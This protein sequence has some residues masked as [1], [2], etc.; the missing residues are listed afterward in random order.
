MVVV[1]SS[2][3][4]FIQVVFAPP[5]TKSFIPE[6]KT[7]WQQVNIFNSSALKTITVW[8]EWKCF[9]VAFEFLWQTFTRE[10]KSLFIFQIDDI[11]V[12]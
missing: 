6:S 9:P 10:D 5:T 2:W 3:F 8:Q 12:D 4:V 11:Q 1:N 7:I